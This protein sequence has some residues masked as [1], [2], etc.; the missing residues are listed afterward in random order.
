[1]PTYK[2][3]TTQQ[4]QDFLSQPFSSNF[5]FS[6]NQIADWFMAQ[7]GARPVINSYGVTKANL[8]STYI[9]KLKE[10]LG[11]YA[12]FLFYT[13]TESGGAGNW[14]NHYG[15]DT[16]STGLGCLIDDC[17]YLLSVS[18]QNL[19]VAL[20]APEVFQPAQEDNS[21]ACQ[22]FYNSLGSTTIG[23]VFMPSTMAGNAWVWA[24]NWCTANQGS[25]PYVYFGNPYDQII[26]TIKNSGADP[27]KKG[28]QTPDLSGKSTGGKA[29]RDVAKGQQNN[30]LAEA[31]NKLKKGIEDIF[32]HNVYDLNHGQSYSNRVI[33]VTRMYDNVLKVSLNDDVLTGLFS[34]IQGSV[35]GTTKKIDWSGGAIAKPQQKTPKANSGQKTDV[36]SKVN[37]VRSL[38]GQTI[39]DG[40]CYALVSW[41]VNSITTGYHI[42]Y[43]LGQIP[44]AFIKGD[45]L[46]AA[47]IGSGYDWASIG[48]TV[49]EPSKTNLKVGDIFNVAANVQGVWYT[50]WA[51]H[52]GVVTGYDGTTVEVTD[53]N[54]NSA[55]VSVRSYNVDQFLYGLTSLISPP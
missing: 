37:A 8:L 10:K 36:P 47:N 11:G 44:P 5:G 38:Q 12:F 15:S 43:S 53:Q 41:Y 34:I 32:T 20:S 33:T 16:S 31:L 9:P 40:Q 28:S 17:D 52:T 25:V 35:T 6:E 13:V 27:F 22:A 45:I 55:P 29:I 19:P 50:S 18:K 54:W 2:Q 49:K 26:N 21:G 46:R 24:T 42:S 4:Y 3:Y 1:M 14:I 7:G 30:A 51:G 23:K 48:W 39:G